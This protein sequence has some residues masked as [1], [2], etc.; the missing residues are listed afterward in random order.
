MHRTFYNLA[1]RAQIDSV[2]RRAIAG[3]LTARMKWT[4]STAQVE[5][6]RSAVGKVISIATARQARARQTR[7]RL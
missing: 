2:V 1:R 4:Y 3:H 6:R 7:K 5:E